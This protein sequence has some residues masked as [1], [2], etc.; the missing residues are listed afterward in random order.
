MT[1]YSAGHEAE[2]LAADYLRTQGFEIIQLN[3]KTKTCEI[4]I[5][6]Q[7]DD[8]LFFIEVKSRKTSA[9]GTGFEYITTKKQKQM[10]FAAELYV[11]VNNWTR[12]YR[13]GAISVDRGVISFIE[14]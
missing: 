2:R 9:Q 11:A 3:W 14:L 1:N 4:D 7:R 10:T 8:I 5:V 13:L 6:A 12:D